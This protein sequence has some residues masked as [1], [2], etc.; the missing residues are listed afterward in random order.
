MGCQQELFGHLVYPGI[1]Y[2]TGRWVHEP[3]FLD[4]NLRLRVESDLPGLEAGAIFQGL[5]HQS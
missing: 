1:P 5:F 2:N 3:C 4:Q